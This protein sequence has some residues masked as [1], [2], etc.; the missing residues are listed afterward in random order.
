MKGDVNMKKHYYIH[1]EEV[2]TLTGKKISEERKLLSNDQICKW[3]GNLVMSEQE[4]LYI[5]HWVGDLMQMSM[6]VMKKIDG[7]MRL[8]N[9]NVIIREEDG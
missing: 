4:S 6:Q 3:I 5:T 9:I 1:I 7:R 8:V 2:D